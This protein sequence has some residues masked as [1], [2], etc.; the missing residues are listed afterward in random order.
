MSDTPILD[1][2]TW[3]SPTR[4][5]NWIKVELG[6]DPIEIDPNDP[7]FDSFRKKVYNQ[8]M[9][10]STLHGGTR[11]YISVDQTK[12]I[13]FVWAWLSADKVYWVRP[14]DLAKAVDATTMTKVL[15]KEF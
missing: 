15:L 13:I 7:V 10:G 8:A 1:K 6:G 4:V 2:I 5:Y 9:L 11:Y 14:T 3:G 12:S